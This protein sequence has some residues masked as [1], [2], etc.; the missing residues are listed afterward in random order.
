MHSPVMLYKILKSSVH[1]VS[2]NLGQHTVI[3][4]II[5]SNIYQMLYTYRVGIIRCSVLPTKY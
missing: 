5:F 2:I 3:F 1:S 4:T